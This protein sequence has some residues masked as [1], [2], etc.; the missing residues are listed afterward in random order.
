MN[1][2]PDDEPRTP[3]VGDRRRR[4]TRPW[5][6]FLRP[7]RRR[8]HRR[9]EDHGPFAFID[10]YDESLGLLILM[11]LVLTL[12]DGILTMILIDICCEEANPV[13][14]V[15]IERGPMAFIL[16]KYL[17]T[18]VCLPV[19]LVFQHH[20][21]FGTRFRVRHLFPAFVALYLLLLGYQIH[22]LRLA[23]EA[24]HGRSD[25]SA[26]AATATGGRP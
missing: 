1:E 3:R 9:V 17:M 16:G 19:L 2:Q 14:A 6:A 12:T 8:R 13:M 21:M 7:S 24:I 5:D 18:A 22:L 11:L 26:M 15:L 20:R 23:S 4:P 25:P 10:R